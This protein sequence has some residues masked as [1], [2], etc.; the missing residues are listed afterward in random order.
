MQFIST[1]EVKQIVIVER[2]Q[3][4]EDIWILGDKF[5]ARTIQQYLMMRD[6]QAVFM[7]SKYEIRVITGGRQYLNR[8]VIGRTRNALVH[9]FAKYNKMPRF[10]IIAFEDDVIEDIHFN[11]FGLKVLYGEILDWLMTEIKQIL[12]NYRQYL[13]SRAKRDG[14]PQVIW[15][16]PSIHI[17]YTNNNKRSKFADSLRSVI[18]L[19]NDATVFKLKKPWNE[20]DQEFY[21][22]APQRLSP[23]GA[24]TYWLAVDDIVKKCDEAL[25]RYPMRPLRD[26][27][28]QIPQP[29]RNDM[30][31]NRFI[32]PRPR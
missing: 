8:S 9:A 4:I 23:H 17:S 27:N 13:P 11:D 31:N 10:I 26:T 19:F 30:R 16:A 28:E 6:E 3:G 7:K 20:I 12:A 29:R 1:Y 5:V 18:E 24:R 22:Y 32:L 14:Y 21:M 25:A 2:P 15:I